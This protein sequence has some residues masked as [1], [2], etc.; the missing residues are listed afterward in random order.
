MHDLEELERK[1][2]RYR[3]R[4]LI[5]WA[6]LSVLVLLL[7]IYFIFREK[8]SAYHFAVTQRQNVTMTGQTKKSQGEKRDNMYA[9]TASE[10]ASNSSV[11]HTKSVSDGDGELGEKSIKPGMTIE[12]SEP[13]EAPKNLHRKTCMKIEL[14]N[15]YPQKRKK[16]R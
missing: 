5:P 6:T 11:I 16:D 13:G 12:I 10:M 4:K 9:L 1:W 15:R 14:T 8:F 3:I 2:K 7:A